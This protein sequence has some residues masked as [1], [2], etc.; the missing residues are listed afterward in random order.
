ML[1]TPVWRHVDRPSLGLS[2][3][4]SGL[5]E[6][7]ERRNPLLLPDLRTATDLVIATDYGGEHKKAR[8]Q[9]ITFLLTDP[10]QLG[11][12]LY[13]REEVRKANFRDRRRMSFKK[14]AERSR[15]R[16]LKPFLCAANTIPGLLVVFLLDRRIDTLFDHEKEWPPPKDVIDVAKWHR[17]S[18][19]KLLRIAHFGGVLLSGMS[20]LGQNVLWITDEDEIVSNKQRHRE[21]TEVIGRVTCAYLQHQMG[22]FRLAT[23]QSD[24][25]SLSVED[26]LSIPDLVSGATGELATAAWARGGIPKGLIVPLPDELS[27]KSVEIAMWLS[28]RRQPLKRMVFL[29]APG[30][31]NRQ[32]ASLLA[33]YPPE[34]GRYPIIVPS[35]CAL[36]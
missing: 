8:F 24:D 22:H 31:S 20:G 1:A 19:E 23:A 16:A 17:K 27:R 30:Q 3:C 33:F 18:F 4:I 15:A 32:T 36:L 26:I 5:I 6:S 13:A 12:W 2:N 34:S 11:L 29:I 14:L 10:R 21:A 9:S 35:N 28:D 25:G 7:E